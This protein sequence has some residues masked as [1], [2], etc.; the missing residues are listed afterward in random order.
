M[1]DANYLDIQ[2]KPGL[3]LS[4][5][6]Q[7]RFNPTVRWRVELPQMANAHARHLAAG[8]RWNLSN[9]GEVVN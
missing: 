5:R 8:P 3:G 7:V 4:K 1:I 2:P 9:S 6:A